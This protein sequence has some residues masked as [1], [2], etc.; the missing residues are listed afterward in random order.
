LGEHE[1]VGFML[2]DNAMDIHQSRLVIWHTAW[3][4]DRGRVRPK[5][6]VAGRRRPRWVDLDGNIFEWDSQHGTVE[7]HNRRG[8]HTGEFDHVTGRQIS[9]RIAGRRVEP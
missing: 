4:L 3:P 5:T 8:E 2:A 9:E 7:R 1:G 6:R